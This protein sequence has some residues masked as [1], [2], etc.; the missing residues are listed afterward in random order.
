MEKWGTQSKPRYQPSAPP[1][2]TLDEAP[3]EALLNV[4]AL[5]SFS[6]QMLRLALL[7]CNKGAGIETL[8]DGLEAR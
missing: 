2:S 6:P 7:Q 1:S 4:V 5:K 3:D 8:I